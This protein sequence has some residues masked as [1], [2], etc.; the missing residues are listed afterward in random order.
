MNHI[1]TKTD[2]NHNADLND[3]KLVVITGASSGFGRASARLFASK[4]WLVIAAARRV[5]RLQDL[6]EELGEENCIIHPL[7]V[8]QDDSI[9]QFVTF[10]LAQSA[11]ID[12]LINNAGLALGLAPAH[13]ADMVEWETMIQ[14]N[15]LGLIKITRA[16][17]P[18]M[19]ENKHG[20][21]INLGS[22]AGDYSYPGANVY[23]ATKA[24]VERFSLNLRADLAGSNV[25]VTNIEPGLA[26]TEFSE[27]RFGGDKEKAANIYNEVKPLVA[28]DIAESIYWCASQPEHVNINRMEIMATCQSSGPFVISK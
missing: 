13:Q 19:V 6:R 1:D 12:V 9:N 14:T 4:G 20:H 2:T 7:D 3:R 17:L 23:G 21:I 8:T 22:V 26:E 11:C 5:Q 24:F 10:V 18:E 27:V 25:R 28:E 16:L 15:I